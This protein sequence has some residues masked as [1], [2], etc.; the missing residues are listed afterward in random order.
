[1]SYCGYFYCSVHERLSEVGHYPVCL[2]SVRQGQIYEMVDEDV[3]QTQDDI[4]S[5]GLTIIV[6]SSSLFFCCNLV[7]LDSV[8]SVASLRKL[9]CYVLGTNI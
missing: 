9:S 4:L 1:M 8:V 7:D 6:D 3:N 2:W 5:L